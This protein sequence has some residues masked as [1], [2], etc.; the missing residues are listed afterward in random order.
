MYTIKQIY[1]VAKNNPELISRF[2][3]SKGEAE[4]EF[5][6]QQPYNRNQQFEH[7]D[8]IRWIQAGPLFSIGV[9]AYHSP[10]EIRDLSSL[11]NWAAYH[12]LKHYYKRHNRMMRAQFALSR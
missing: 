3:S 12:I 1:N 4:Y 6:I 8:N 10:N 11:Q 2:L 9:I 5:N 7:F